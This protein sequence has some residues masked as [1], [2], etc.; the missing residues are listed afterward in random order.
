MIS[1]YAVHY[2]EKLVHLGYTLILS[3]FIVSNPCTFSNSSGGKVS[4][5]SVTDCAVLYSRNY[6]H[7]EG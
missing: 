2:L 7:D 4:S 6:E 3:H 5:S 1:R